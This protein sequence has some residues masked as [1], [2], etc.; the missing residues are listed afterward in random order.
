MRWVFLTLSLVAFIGAGFMHKW[1]RTSYSSY[2]ESQLQLL[3]AEST[4]VSALRGPGRDSARFSHT[5]I[6][7]ERERRLILWGFLAVGPLLA[8]LG[9]WVRRP[10]RGPTEEDERLLGYLSQERPSKPPPP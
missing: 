2:S 5:V 1:R 9:F 3:E 10:P 7:E 6:E 4:A 8:I